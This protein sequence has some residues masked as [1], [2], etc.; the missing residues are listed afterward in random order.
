ML[1]TGGGSPA[2]RVQRP[3][4]V[5]Q[6]GGRGSDV[7]GEAGGD[8]EAVPGVGDRGGKQFLEQAL[9]R[10]VPARR[11]MRPRLPAPDTERGPLPG[12]RS[13]ARSAKN[14]GVASAPARARSRSART[15]GRLQPHGTARRR[16]RRQPFMWGRTTARTPAIATAT[17]MA[18]PP[19][20]STSCLPRPRAGGRPRPHHRSRA[21]RDGWLAERR[22]RPCPRRRTRS[23][24]GSGRPAPQPISAK[25]RNAV[26]RAGRVGEGSH[27]SLGDRSVLHGR[28]PVCESPARMHRCSNGRDISGTGHQVN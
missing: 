21:L 13:S 4:V 5:V 20:R 8:G 7:A 11:P 3:R 10:S 2:R 6:R 26:G 23:A 24:V 19:R 27:N 9:F 14:S 15:P 17:S 1:P 18:L 22:C 28:I 16:R 25:K 12:I